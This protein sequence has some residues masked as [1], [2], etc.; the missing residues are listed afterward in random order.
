MILLVELLL[1]AFF[2]SAINAAEPPFK[3]K[4]NVVLSTGKR[5]SFKV[6]VHPE[7]A[8]LGAARFKTLVEADFFRN[9]RFFR[10]I[11]GFMAQFGI[12]GKPS[13]AAKW[14]ERTLVDDPVIQSNKRGFI[15]FATSG[16]DSRTTQMFINFGDNSNLDNMGFAPFAKV[17]GDGM[18]VVD[19][20]YAGYG[21]GAPSGKG[22]E[23]GRIQSEGNS[24][25]KKEFPKLSFII[26]VEMLDEQL[27]GSSPFETLPTAWLI[28][29]KQQVGKPTLRKH[30]FVA[31]VM[32]LVLRTSSQSS[33]LCVALK[34]YFLYLSRYSG[35]P[36][37]SFS[38]LRPSQ[39]SESDYVS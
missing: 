32:E 4:F 13:I 39:G 27:S 19:Q 21:E 24:Y 18:E 20:I 37:S 1:S 35:R 10:V 5:D 6:E 25:L 11:S 3:V 36:S 33:L 29:P 34:L 23:Q 30:E 26:S 7:W 12:S 17:L 38:Q 9:V 31:R 16:K 28:N 22:P 8:P 14:R 15:S 2:L